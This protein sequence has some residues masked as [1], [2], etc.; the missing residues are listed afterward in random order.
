MA[1]DLPGDLVVDI[2]QPILGDSFSWQ[3]I[4]PAPAKKVIVIHG[5]AGQNPSEDGFSMAEQHVNGNGWDG[6]GVHFV[7]T[8]DNYPGRPGQTSGGT[9]IQYVGDLL[10]WRAGVL[11]NNPGR[12]HI[13]ICGLFT[14]GNGV[15]SEAQLRATRKLVDFLL[16]PNN[17]LPSLNYYSQVDYHNHQA[18]PGGGTACP[19]WENP[20]F[21]EWFG[22]LQ[23]GP[24]PTWWHPAPA[25]APEPTPE[26]TPEP[27]PA[28]APGDL[29]PNSADNRPEW[30][31]T[32]DPTPQ[33]LKIVAVPSAEVFDVVANVVVKQLPG[34]EPIKNIAGT[35]TSNGTKY[36]RTQY[37]VD[38]GKWNGVVENQLKDPEPPIVE[39]IVSSPGTPVDSIQ[40]PVATIDAPIPYDEDTPASTSSPLHKEEPAE[41]S[42]TLASLWEIIV[43]IVL[44]PL[45]LIAIISKYLKGLQK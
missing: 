5:T 28:P 6:I 36:V 16:A 18:T 42:Q 23:G 37:A 10:S 8:H 15:P 31:K 24:E 33:S 27:V 29:V 39:P 9:Q 2:R 41:V 35:F 26:P 30:E 21:G 1:I 11:N 20:Q 19:G 12:V 43:G 34:G 25:P 7:I 45:R 44:A 17:I 14:P 13:E 38:H 4:E 22:Y 32:W 3:G 40:P